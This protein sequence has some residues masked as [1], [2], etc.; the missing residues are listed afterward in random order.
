[1]VGV[2]LCDQSVAFDL[3]DHSLLVEKLRLM[4]VD[5]SFANWLLSYL[6]DRKQSC[7]VDGHMSS[8]LELPDCGV[9]QGSI[10]G[11][12]LW[13]IFTC[14]QPDV[15]HEHIMNREKVDRGCA[16]HGGGYG[17]LVGYVDDGGYCCADKDPA[18][19]SHVLT[20]KFCKLAEW[21]HSNKL[22]LNSDKTH[23]LVLGSRRHINLTA[24]VTVKAG[25]STIR[26]SESEKLLGGQLHQNLGWASHIRDHSSSLLRQLSCR[27][28]G[29]KK[30]CVNASF[31]TKVMVANGIVMSKLTYLITL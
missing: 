25:E 6:S 8:P 9:P 13:L 5:E 18:V 4:G 11:P 7:I 10:G 3:C 17:V 31:E 20:T 12:I 24:L 21:M 28:N 15:I 30:V 26:P 23:L 2:L 16:D 29:L 14:D 19:L 1:M 22:V 27:I